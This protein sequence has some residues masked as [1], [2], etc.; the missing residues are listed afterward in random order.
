LNCINL[1]SRTR[2]NLS[3]GAKFTSNEFNPTIN[4]VAVGVS[5]SSNYSVV[6]SVGGAEK[7][8]ITFAITAPYLPSLDL[9]FSSTL[10]FCINKI[11]VANKKP[12][13]L[14]YSLHTNKDSAEHDGIYRDDGKIYERSARLLT[15]ALHCASYNVSLLN[16]PNVSIPC[17]NVGGT[18]YQVN[19]GFIS[20]PPSSPFPFCLN[21]SSATP[22]TLPVGVQCP[23]G[24]PTSGTLDGLHLDCLTVTPTESYWVD[25]KWTPP[26]L[27]FGVTNLGL[28]P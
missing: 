1:L 12:V 13:N 9:P 11:Q 18:N 10:S 23:V 25:M 26:S 27:N 5:S 2:V 21:V 15:F 8:F 3:N 14:T 19:M 20:C 24:F 16:P 17:V 7:D 28:N 4:G 6:K 22:I